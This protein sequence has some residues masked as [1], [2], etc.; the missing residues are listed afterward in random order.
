MIDSLF[1]TLER[2]PDDLDTYLVLADALTRAGDPRG[3]L[4]AIQHALA[5]RSD[6]D[7]GA[8]VAREAE[9]VAARKRTLDSVVHRQAVGLNFR[10]GFLDQVTLRSGLASL[11]LPRIL[12][13][14]FG[15]PESRLLRGIAI[16][17]DEAQA[18]EDRFHALVAQLRDGSQAAPASLRR[19]VLGRDYERNPRCR[20]STDYLYD[21]S[22]KLLGVFDVF[23]SIEELRV[24]LVANLEWEPLVSDRLRRFC[25]VCP[26]CHDH[27]LEQF[28]ASRLPALES[29]VLWTGGQY[30]V[31]PEGAA[32]WLQP[33]PASVD[34]ED[35]IAAADLVPLLAMLARSPALRELGICNFAGHFADLA[36]VLANSPVLDR[37]ASLDLSACRVA[38]RDSATLH[39]LLDRAPNLRTLKIANAEIGPSVLVELRARSGLAIVGEPAGELHRPYR[40]FVTME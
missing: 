7:R 30:V 40:Y 33:L 35:G 2:D 15:S 13:A 39:A 16:E 34:F 4:I 19:L 32:P 26:H 6:V 11:E 31:D 24:D 10:L 20:V 5:T 29:L 23:P 14:L 28:V 1:A 17:F 21:R 9:L 22:D 18:D 8:L 27:E 12:C 25:Y 36:D 3:E 37:I 38:E